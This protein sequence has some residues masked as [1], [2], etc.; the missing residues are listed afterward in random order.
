MKLFVTML[1]LAT[2]AISAYADCDAPRTAVLRWTPTPKATAYR[3]HYGR[4][5]GEL[6]H[7]IEVRDPSM[8]WFAVKGLSSG[9]WY[10]AVRG[11]VGADESSLSK[12][13]KRTVT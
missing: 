6:V 9:S 12:V 11:V 7:A 10:F 1:L 5:T 13:Q 4:K 2:F 8:C 3:I